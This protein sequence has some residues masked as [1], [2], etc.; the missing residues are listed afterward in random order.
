MFFLVCVVVLY[1]SVGPNECIA[2][3]KWCRHTVCLALSACWIFALCKFRLV[4]SDSVLL[5]YD[6]KLQLW[7]HDHLQFEQQSLQVTQLCIIRFLT[8]KL[9]LS[10]GILLCSK[11]QHKCNFSKSWEYFD[12]W[13]GPSANLRCPPVQ[14]PHVRWPDFTKHPKCWYFA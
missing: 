6:Q 2:L 5:L 10:C 7:P 3:V 12:T 14:Q 9:I 4:V 8:R 11:L 1:V 13:C